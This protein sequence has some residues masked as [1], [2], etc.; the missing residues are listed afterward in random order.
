MVGAVH[1]QVMAKLLRGIDMASPNPHDSS[2]QRV[3]L[4]ALHQM[5]QWPAAV[6]VPWCHGSVT[7]HDHA[8]SSHTYGGFGCTFELPSATHTHTHTQVLCL[9]CHGR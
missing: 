4:F 1:L 6:K 5:S 7:A 3:L 8:M 9:L 2:L